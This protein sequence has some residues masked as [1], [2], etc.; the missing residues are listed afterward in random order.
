MKRLIK[1]LEK[2]I[3]WLIIVLIGLCI[4]VGTMQVIFRFILHAPLAWS[5]E[6]IRYCF[7]WIVFVGSSLAVRNNSHASIS[8]FVELIP[9]TIRNIFSLLS[10]V[11]CIAFSFVILV[12]G[13]KIM[14]MQMKTQQLTAALEIPIAFVFLAI[15][16]GAI[17]MMLYYTKNILQIFIKHKL[18]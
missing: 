6:F 15:P 17:G 11:L 5:E 18:E 16:V 12:E 9:K 8:F 4:I 2:I 14:I 13:I 7:V 1:F 10:N 3:E